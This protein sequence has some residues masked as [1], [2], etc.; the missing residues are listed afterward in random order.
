MELKRFVCVLAIATAVL[1]EAPV[2]ASAAS[3]IF[4]AATGNHTYTQF[5][6][7]SWG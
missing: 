1:L 3:K 6:A 4:N 7:R 5:F 2:P